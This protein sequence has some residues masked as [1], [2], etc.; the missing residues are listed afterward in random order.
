M[1]FFSIGNF[2]TTFVNY[3]RYLCLNKGSLLLDPSSNSSS[4]PHPCRPKSPTRRFWSRWPCPPC[5]HV[6]LTIPWELL[7]ILYKR[8]SFRQPRPASGAEWRALDRKTQLGT[9][10][11]AHTK[12]TKRT[13]KPRGNI[14]NKHLLDIWWLFQLKAINSGY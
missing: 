5:R 9:K 4:S 2:L 14:I 3:R 7:L 12:P 13:K 10:K 6:G 8:L 11:K 1:C